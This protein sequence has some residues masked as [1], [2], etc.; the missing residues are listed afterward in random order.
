MENGECIMNIE[1]L[2]G[3]L[4]KHSRKNHYEN[5]MYIDTYGKLVGPCPL[6]YLDW[7]DRIKI[8]DDEIN[9]LCNPGCSCICPDE[10]LRM[11]KRKCKKAGI[12][13]EI[14]MF[15]GAI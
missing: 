11:F 12:M 3:A 5:E 13:A 15:G 6:F 2:T 4:I 8:T 7:G 14:N 9:R 1:T 10:F